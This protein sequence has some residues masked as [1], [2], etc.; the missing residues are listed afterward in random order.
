MKKKKHLFTH[1][2]EIRPAHSRAKHTFPTSWTKLIWAEANKH[3]SAE[4]FEF[5]RKMKA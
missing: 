2:N 5:A 3:K 1:A 4:Y